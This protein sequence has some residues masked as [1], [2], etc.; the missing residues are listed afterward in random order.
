MD[1]NKK[2]DETSSTHKDCCGDSCKCDKHTDEKSELEQLKAEQEEL[3]K[4]AAQLFVAYEKLK[5]DHTA[6]TDK[7]ARVI[8]EYDNF[9]R[10]SGD[11]MEAKYSQACSDIVSALLPVA[12]NLY[13][14]IAH[15]P[16]ES[17]PLLAGVNMT[18]A[19]FETSLA[20]LGVSEVE[21]KTFDP[22]LHHAVSHET[23]SEHGTGEIVEVLQRGYKIGEKII[24]YAMVRVV[25]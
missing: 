18:I 13:R 4:A 9:R 20:A 25:N 24:R 16:D 21:T 8:N 2:E 15:S 6:Q 7:L 10:R 3:Q 19:Q 5:T 17:N 14:A 12:D 1:I 22:E 23:S 11:E